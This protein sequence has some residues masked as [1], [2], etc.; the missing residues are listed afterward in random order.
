MGS[1]IRNDRLSD[2]S[3][4]GPALAGRQKPLHAGLRILGG[5]RASLRLLTLLISLIEV[6]ARF[7]VLRLRHRRDL[8]LWQRAQ[9]LHAAC[10]LILRRLKLNLECRGQRPAQGLICSN[11]LSYLD[12]LVY[13]ATTPC[14]FV[15][16]QE[17]RRWPAFGFFAR[18]GRTIF[19]DRQSRS[20]AEKA[21]V[22]MASVLKAGVPILLFPEG[23]STDGAEVLRFHPT[24][25]EPAVQLNQEI[26]AAAIGY[27]APG[28]E[29]R[30][31]CWFGEDPFL[32]HLL[33]TLARTRIAAEV[34]FFPDRMSYTGRKIAAL[35]LREQVD[36]MR[37]R[38]KRQSA[39]AR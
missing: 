1:R 8:E 12:I 22:Q 35:E 29:E 39:Q 2:P 38:M 11:H 19:L 20:S 21:A 5:I 15:S 14:V 16:K 37:K 24:L 7:L 9:W 32:P 6:A 4:S 27:R 30:D 25:L 17:V 3:R 36:A 18:C 26:T 13:A 33:R 10:A 31:L 28:V 34:E 23:T